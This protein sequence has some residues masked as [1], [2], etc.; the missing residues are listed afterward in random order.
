M[1]DYLLVE[2]YCAFQ[3]DV[4]DRGEATVVSSNSSTTDHPYMLASRKYSHERTII[5]VGER[6]I[7]G[8]QVIIMAGPCAVESRE[9]ILDIASWVKAANG[10]VLRGGA[11]KPRSSPYSFQGLGEKGLELLA[12]ARQRIGIPIVTEVMEPAQVPN[13]AFYADILQVGA[14]NMQNYP[15]LRAVGRTQKP[16]LLKRGMGNRL[17]ELLLSAEYILSE[18]NPNVILCERGIRTFETVTRNTFDLNAIPVLKYL[19]HLPVIADPSHGVGDARYV[20]A[21]ARGAI[22]AGADGIIVEVHSDPSQALSDGKQ[23]LSPAMFS[24]FMRD[25]TRVAQAVGRCL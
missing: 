2:K 15:L 19:T 22:A 20:T 17:E 4:Y 14:R 24:D 5:S 25:I 3:K 21:V 13:V 11:F 12:E 10:S 16:I 18:G 1:I 8:E 23:S 9:Q 6:Q 7:G